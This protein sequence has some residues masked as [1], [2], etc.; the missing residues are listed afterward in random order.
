MP[1]DEIDRHQPE[2]HSGPS[3]SHP[4]LAAFLAFFGWSLN[5]A[6]AVLA[7]W[8]IKSL[9]FTPQ[10]GW[11]GL[12]AVGAVLPGFALVGLVLVL[13]TILIIVAK[14]VR[15]SQGSVSRIV[16]SVAITFSLI[17]VSV[18]Y[19][20]YSITRPYHASINDH[21][22]Q[23]MYDNRSG[24]LAALPSERRAD[25]EDTLNFLCG[26]ITHL[27]KVDA[28]KIFDVMSEYTNAAGRTPNRARSESAIDSL[29]V[30]KSHY[31][32]LRPQYR[33]SFGSH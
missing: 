28:Q 1:K 4:R 15:R 24:I 9:F 10:E 31:E 5:I 29:N 20:I 23:L 6:G 19:P 18:G 21:A 33:D 2:A 8:F 11:G 16:W 7:F 17:G 22:W 13:G 3:D 30:I 14:V 26:M 32:Y 25:A 12:I 27:K